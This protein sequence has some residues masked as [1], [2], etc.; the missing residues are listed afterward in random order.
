MPPFSSFSPA[1][2]QVTTKER[3]RQKWRWVQ[4]VAAVSSEFIAEWGV[5]VNIKIIYSDREFFHGCRFKKIKNKKI[6]LS[7]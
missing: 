5:T 4:L 1:Q 2:L 3:E 7:M 6:Y